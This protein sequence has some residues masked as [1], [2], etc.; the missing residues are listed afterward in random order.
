[1]TALVTNPVT[2]P[3]VATAPPQAHL[4][5]STFLPRRIAMSK[6]PSLPS[7][8]RP[9]MRLLALGAALVAPGQTVPWPPRSTPPLRCHRLAS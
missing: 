6:T 8:F 3:V 2:R 9:L 5:V 1:M 7:Q 4:S